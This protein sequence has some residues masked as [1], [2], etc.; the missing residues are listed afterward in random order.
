MTEGPRNSVATPISDLTYRD[1]DGPLLSRRLRWWSVTA[2]GL[3]T[4]WRL[5]LRAIAFW[6]CAVLCTGPYLILGFF[7]WITS[8]V[9][10]GNSR[11]FMGSAP[12]VRFAMLFYFALRLQHLFLFVVALIAG[13]GS[14]SADNKANALIV[15]LAKPITK[16]DYLLGKWAN[17]FIVV[18]GAALVPALMLYL[19]CLAG[20]TSEGFLRDDPWLILRIVAVS[21][22]A[23]SV[24]AS[25]VLGF[26]AWCR[27]PRTASAVYSAVYWGAWSIAF[28]LTLRTPDEDM[29]AAQ[30][31]VAHLSIS[32]VFIGLAQ[33]IYRVTPSRF[34]NADFP[35]PPPWHVLS[36]VAVVLVLGGIAAARAR[37]RAVEVIRG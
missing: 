21:A 12:G 3:R 34:L 7:L 26:S 18:F 33:N 4:L 27:T 16:M 8:T 30:S 10:G 5:D 19:Y 22:I 28:A 29:T 37:I 17:I 15:Y 6:I 20:Y 14:V 23:A 24:H 36:V 13:A 2:G 9:A 25:L 32:G 31:L 1:Y 35:T 11:A